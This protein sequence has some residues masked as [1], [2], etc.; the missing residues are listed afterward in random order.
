MRQHVRI[1][2]RILPFWEPCVLATDWL[3]S[4]IEKAEMYVGWL[5]SRGVP[6]RLEV[7]R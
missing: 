7:G 2:V 6:I 3:P 1:L 4:D 5:N